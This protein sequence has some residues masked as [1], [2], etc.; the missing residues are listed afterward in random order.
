VIHVEL[1]AGR[2]LLSLDGLT[3]VAG[4]D[5]RRCV[6]EAF[7]T[8]LLRYPERRIVVACRLCTYEGSRNA[9][10]QLPSGPTLTL[11][12]WTPHEMQHFIRAWYH[13]AAIAG[14]MTEAKRDERMEIPGRLACRVGL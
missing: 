3:N 9:E 11:A 6:R 7:W 10:W 2:V 13:A 12:E 8:F 1:E 5:S 4:R 14:V